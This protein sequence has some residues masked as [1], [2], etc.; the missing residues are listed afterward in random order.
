MPDAKAIQA[1]CIQCTSSCRTLDCWLEKMDA[2]KELIVPIF[3]KTY[4]DDQWRK[5]WLNWR[6]FFIVCSETFGIKEGSE[7]GVSNYLF[8]VK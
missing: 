3:K 6:M 2:N 8:E 4:G 1:K 7:W 5:W